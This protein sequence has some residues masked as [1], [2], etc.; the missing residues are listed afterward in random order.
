MKSKHFIAA[1]L[2]ALIFILSS[3]AP[4]QVQGQVDSKEL[5]KFQGTWELVAGELDGQQIKD[6]NLKNSR[7][8][9]TGT[10]I[11]VFTPH[12]HKDTIISTITR[13]DM[14]KDPKEMYWV[15]VAG[16]N[17]GTTMSAIYKFDG[18]DQCQ[19]CF[20]TKGKASSGKFETAQGSGYLWHIWK[21]VKK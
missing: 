3:L 16:P 2:V 7:M 14:S 21:R 18:P 13:I 8:I 4:K 20:D 6:E 10:R 12:Q 15:R 17:T 19:F 5:K 11:I 9:F 1:T